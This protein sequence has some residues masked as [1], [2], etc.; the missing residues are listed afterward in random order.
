MEEQK[1]PLRNEP[2]RRYMAGRV[3]PRGDDVYNPADHHR[4]SPVKPAVTPDKRIEEGPPKPVDGI[5]KPP[6]KRS[7]SKTKPALPRPHRSLVLKRHLIE[8]ADQHRKQVRTEH[9]KHFASMV[10]ALIVISALAVISWVFWDFLPVVKSVS[11]PFIGHHQPTTPDLTMHKESSNLDQ[12]KPGEGE[13]QTY[14]AAADAPR[15][16]KIPKLEIEARV[17]RVGTSLNGE[18][19]SPS[20]I[21]DVGWFDDSSKPGQPGTVLINGHIA[22]T[23]KD[24]VFH[25]LGSL[26]PNDIIQIERGDKTVLTYV[27]NKVQTY[28]GDQIDMNT[29]LQ[30]IVADK[31]GLNLMTSSANYDGGVG[32]SGQRVIVFAV[33][34]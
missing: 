9:K 31:N 7:I 6:R 20:N 2:G 24:G 34:K 18:P 22:G 12:N 28:S 1:R 5:A 15:I 27:V 8:R 14:Q 26:L 32:Q 11:I 25:D 33:Q 4:T 21:F 23:S 17:K 13:V 16:L 29:A 10:V 30:S 3:R 19:I